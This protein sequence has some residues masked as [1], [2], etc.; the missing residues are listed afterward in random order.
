MAAQM[1]PVPALDLRPTLPAA[2]D[3]LGDL[4][5]LAFLKTESDASGEALDVA[6]TGHS[7]G[8]ALAPAVALWLKD[9][10][11][12]GRPAERWDATGRARISCHAFAGPTPGN[13]GFARR[14]DDVLGADH[15]HLRNVKDVVTHAWQAD[16]L[17]Q[18]PG[19]YGLRSAV[20]GP[21]IRLIVADTRPLDYRQAR[22]GVRTFTGR[23]LAAGFGAAPFGPEFVHQHMEAYLEELGLDQHGIHALTFF[24]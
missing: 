24:A 9:A 17:G 7:K 19:L 4:D 11:A 18:I 13:A 3:R 20:F 6:V 22:R 16:E 10:L 21:L 8:G 12:S 2:I 15:H 23:P 1:S 5:L 14:L